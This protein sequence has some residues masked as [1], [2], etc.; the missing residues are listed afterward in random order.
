MR[1]SHSN[2]VLRSIGGAR[3]TVPASK[4]MVAPNWALDRR[5]QPP[6]VVQ[7]PGLGLFGAKKYRN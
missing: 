2:P 3:R 7:Q 5:P 1:H 4:L 6:M